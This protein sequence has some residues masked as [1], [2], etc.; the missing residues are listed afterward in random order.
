VSQTSLLQSAVCYRPSAQHF[1][2]SA[3]AQ[4]CYTE[5][6]VFKPSADLIKRLLATALTTHHPE[7]LTLMQS[8]ELEPYVGYPVCF[9]VRCGP[10]ANTAGGGG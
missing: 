6:T 7:S 4:P 1:R 10:K 5:S 3:A 2:T 8:D 9:A